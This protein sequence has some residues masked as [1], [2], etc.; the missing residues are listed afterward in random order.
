[1]DTQ[2]ADF[3]LSSEENPPEPPLDYKTLKNYIF[4]ARKYCRPRM[5]REAIE[6]IKRFYLNIRSSRAGPD[7]P[8]PITARYLEA[9]IRLSEA[10]AKMALKD[11]VTA[12]DA[13]AAIRLMTYSLNQVGIDQE[14]GMLDVDAI[15]T[16][17]TTTRRRRIS[18]LSEIIRQLIQEKNGAPASIA[19]IIEEAKKYHFTEEQVRNEISNM[20]A[21]GMLYEPR[22]GYYGIIED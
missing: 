5:T 7:A 13:E 22:D 9:L 3:I 15:E 14:T 21:R 20:R 4:Y 2:I 8:V 18:Q 12:E 6:I 11:E 19:E 10:R 1:M 16:G 17:I